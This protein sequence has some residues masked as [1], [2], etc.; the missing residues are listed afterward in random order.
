MRQKVA[1]NTE[2]CFF[3]GEE[4]QVK[5]DKN[6]QYFMA[7]NKCDYVK[8]LSLY[9]FL[10]QWKQTTRITKDAK[11][12]NKSPSVDSSQL[13]IPHDLQE[14]A[15]TSSGTPANN[16]IFIDNENENICTN[17]TSKFDADAKRITDEYGTQYVHL[18]KEFFNVVNTRPYRP[19]NIDTVDNCWSALVMHAKHYSNIEELGDPSDA[20]TTLKAFIQEGKMADSYQ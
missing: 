8:D 9:D 6:I 16:N 2:N 10:C 15:S 12:T 4:H 5:L 14:N 1:D 7:L 3:Q 11:K 19:L 18:K 20:M 13:P 17:S